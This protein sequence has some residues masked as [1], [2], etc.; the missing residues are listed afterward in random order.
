MA[1]RMR[2]VVT[3]ALAAAFLAVASACSADDEPLVVPTYENIVGAYSLYL[4]NGGSI[5]FLAAADGVQRVEIVSG[6]IT[7]NSDRTITDVLR[8]RVSR[9]DGT[10]TPTEIPESRTGTFTIEGGFV[11]AAYD[12]E[13]EPTRITVTNSQLTRDV[14]SFVLSYRK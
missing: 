2:V 6:S 7:M 13:A 14:A 9:V 10:G 8:F 1:T 11:I 4:V 12:G 3:R 5:P